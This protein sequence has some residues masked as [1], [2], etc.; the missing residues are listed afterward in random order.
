MKDTLS[1]T[2]VELLKSV[3]QTLDPDNIFG[4]NNLLPN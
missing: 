2:G 1:N 3:K 4:A